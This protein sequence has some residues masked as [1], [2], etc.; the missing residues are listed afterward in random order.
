MYPGNV[1]ACLQVNSP[2]VCPVETEI[3]RNTSLGTPT[4]ASN[5]R[6]RNKLSFQT[7]PVQGLRRRKNWAAL[8]VLTE[9]LKTGPLTVTAPGNGCQTLPGPR[10]R[11]CCTVKPM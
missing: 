1:A 10:L 11:A 8:V 4:H 2:C 5:Y 6:L 9:T 3:F 7:G